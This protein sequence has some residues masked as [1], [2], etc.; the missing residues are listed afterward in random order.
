MS[1]LAATWLADSPEKGRSAENSRNPLIQAMRR[2]NAK[3]VQFSDPTYY[4]PSENDYSTEGENE[5]ELDFM[6]VAPVAQDDM[7]D[8]DQM[9]DSDVVEPLNVRGAQRLGADDRDSKS[10]ST[11]PQAE[12]SLKRQDDASRASSTTDDTFGMPKSTPRRE[13]LLISTR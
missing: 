6:T 11:T 4:E 13:T 5:D 8:E 2:R 1:K 10:G 7:Q 3:K 9:N 12:D